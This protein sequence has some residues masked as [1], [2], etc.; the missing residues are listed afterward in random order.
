MLAQMDAE[1]M[2]VLHN[3]NH[4]NWLM[5][6]MYVVDFYYLWIIN[7]KLEFI[8]LF[9][10]L[11]HEERRDTKEQKRYALPIDRVEIWYFTASLCYKHCNLIMDCYVYIIVD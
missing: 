11:L 9:W 8:I 10:H 3:Y 6:I 1:Q 5:I 7:S 4:N 2:Q